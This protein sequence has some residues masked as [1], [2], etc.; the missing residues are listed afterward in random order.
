MYTTLIVEKRLRTGE[1]PCLRR[2]EL[3]TYIV[4]DRDGNSKACVVGD[5]QQGLHCAFSSFALR[6]LRPRVGAWLGGTSLFIVTTSRLPCHDQN[7]NINKLAY[8]NI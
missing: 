8:I 5:C 4:G 1:A 2:Q 6:L 3:V 7:N